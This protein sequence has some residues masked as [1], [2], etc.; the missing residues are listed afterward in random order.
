MPHAASTSPTQVMSEVVE[1]PKNSTTLYTSIPRMTRLPTLRMQSRPG[2][3]G[4]K[5]LACSF[6]LPDTSAKALVGIAALVSVANLEFFGLKTEAAP[7]YCGK[8]N[9]A[10]LL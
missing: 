3:Q 6:G 8:Q 2:W 4:P 9:L 5:L 1:Q 10:M 7:E